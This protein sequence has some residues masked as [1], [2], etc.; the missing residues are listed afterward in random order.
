MFTPTR[1]QQ[2]LGGCMFIVFCIFFFCFAVH[3]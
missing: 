3:G 2:M 1:F